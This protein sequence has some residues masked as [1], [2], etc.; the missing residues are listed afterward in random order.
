MGGL[1]KRGGDV[2]VDEADGEGADS[3]DGEGDVVETPAPPKDHPP[4]VPGQGPWA[5]HIK[6]QQGLYCTLVSPSP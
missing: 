3:G 5:N 2:V 4:T 6:F 1:R